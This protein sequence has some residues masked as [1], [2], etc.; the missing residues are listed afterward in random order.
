MKEGNQ[1]STSGKTSDFVSEQPGTTARLGENQ[2]AEASNPLPQETD[3]CLKDVSVES[4]LQ[5]MFQHHLQTPLSGNTLPSIPELPG[6]AASF[7]ESELASTSDASSYQSQ[8]I[9]RRPDDESLLQAQFQHHTQTSI[10]G[11]TPAFVPKWPETTA[12]FSENQTASTSGASRSLSQQTSRHP[13]SV[14][15]QTQFQHDQQTSFAGSSLASVPEQQG[16]TASSIENQSTSISKESLQSGKYPSKVSILH[17]SPKRNIETSLQESGQHSSIDVTSPSKKQVTSI[18]P[19]QKTRTLSSPTK[20]TFASRKHETA[21]RAKQKTHTFSSPIQTTRASREQV[22]AVSP[23]EKKGTLSSPVKAASASEE[24]MTAVRPRQKKGA[25]SSPVE[26]MSASREQATAECPRQQTGPYPIPGEPKLEVNYTTMD[27]EKKF[28][29][30]VDSKSSTDETTD[31]YQAQKA[32]SGTSKRTSSISQ[33]ES[34]SHESSLKDSSSQHYKALQDTK[35]KKDG[36]RLEKRLG[37]FDK[38]ICVKCLA[39]FATQDE[40]LRHEPIHFND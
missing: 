18:H 4:L 17:A 24:Q 37:L 32:S 29:E 21:V 19:S 34:S 7:S 30:F 33:E 36:D 39:E 40:L 20:L 12:S 22:T 31:F 11:N 6:S 16:T 15:L 8:Q 27:V 5:S 35:I 28:P 38:F 9:G 14:L 25:L 10:S 3:R 13:P 1:D 2:S 23:R 26:T